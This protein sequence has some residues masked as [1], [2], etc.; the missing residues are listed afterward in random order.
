[1]HTFHGICTCLV[2]FTP[3]WS[4]VSRLLKEYL[5]PKK[6][7]KPSRDC[8]CCPMAGDQYWDSVGSYFRVQSD[9]RPHSTRVSTQGTSR[10]VYTSRV[11]VAGGVDACNLSG[12]RS[13]A[14][15]STKDRGIFRNGVLVS[16]TL[17]ATS[18]HTDL[19]IPCLGSQARARVFL[20]ALQRRDRVPQNTQNR[21]RNNSTTTV[22]RCAIN[23]CHTTVF[24]YTTSIMRCAAAFVWAAPWRV[25]ALQPTHTGHVRAGVESKESDFS[26]IRSATPVQRTETESGQCLWDRHLDLGCL[27]NLTRSWGY[28]WRMNFRLYMTMGT[29]VLILPDLGGWPQIHSVE[30]GGGWFTLIE[31]PCSCH[32]GQNFTGN[33]AIPT[34]ESS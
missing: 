12:L 14:C 7:M 11:A 29:G 5:V 13:S 2:P 3:K 4:P 6:M 27:Q 21:V 22:L 30:R 17:D 9:L 26:E 19:K 15:T 31:K 23:N 28:V 8:P 33:T 18:L 10:G 20:P 1:M 24:A 25:G 16:C 34:R 32:E